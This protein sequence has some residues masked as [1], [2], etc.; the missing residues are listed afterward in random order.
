ML[1]SCNIKLYER[2]QLSDRMNAKYSALMWH[3]FIDQFSKDNRKEF[4]EVDNL[5][6][7]ETAALVFLANFYKQKCGN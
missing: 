1:L 7:E 4:K 2:E 3:G 6:H 5:L